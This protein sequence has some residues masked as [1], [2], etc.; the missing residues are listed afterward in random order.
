MC[1]RDRGRVLYIGVGE[2][3]TTNSLGNA[4]TNVSL[5][6]GVQITFTSAGTNT[7][8]RSIIDAGVAEFGQFSPGATGTN[9]TVGTKSNTVTNATSFLVPDLKDPMTSSDVVFTLLG[10]PHVEE[11]A[12]AAGQKAALLV[13]TV[14]SRSP[15]ADVGG[16][17]PS[18]SRASTTI[19]GRSA[20]PGA[21]SKDS[22]SG[23]L[24][25]IQGFP[26]ARK[27]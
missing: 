2:M 1:I 3:G 17:T 20:A 18:S 6:S 12:L 15:I 27:P 9:A 26:A 22:L 16:L 19:P 14:S 7:D 5:G 8:S 25:E 13:G 23:T 11:P 10:G 4:T 24:E 21:G